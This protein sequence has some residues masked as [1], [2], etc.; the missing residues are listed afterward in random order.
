MKKEYIKPTTE[1]IEI[2]AQD[3]IVASGFVEKEDTD[4]VLIDDGSSMETPVIEVK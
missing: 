1:V 4:N 2:D 3:V